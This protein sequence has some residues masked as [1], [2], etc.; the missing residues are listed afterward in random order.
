M[1]KT[2]ISDFWN[3]QNG[4]KN[5]ILSLLKEDT[6][7]STLHDTVMVF[8][9]GM[10]KSHSVILAL[11][12]ENLKQIME[13]V[14]EV[15]TKYVIIP[16]VSTNTWIKFERCLF[17][18][19]DDDLVPGILDKELLELADLLVVSLGSSSGELLREDIK[20]ELIQ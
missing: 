4:G 2:K 9:D 1:K 3:I 10:V 11:I 15:E 6:V 13:A 16:S 14:P 5:D 12:S 7:T 19:G 8:R 20:I 17:S 18:L